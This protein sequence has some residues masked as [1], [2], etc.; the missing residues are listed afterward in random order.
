MR[1]KNA[2]E[3]LSPHSS[4]LHTSDLHLRTLAEPRTYHNDGYD[5]D[6]FG[7]TEHSS[8]GV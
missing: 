2:K 6:G 7:E 5:R 8:D 1:E 4:P 3:L